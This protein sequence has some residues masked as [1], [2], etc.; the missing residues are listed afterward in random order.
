MYLGILI[1]HSW[2]RWVAIVAGIGAIW[3][4]WRISSP[5]AAARDRWALALMIALDLQLLLGLL[6]YLVSPV[7]RYA[8]HGTGALRDPTIRFFALDHPLIMCGALILVHLGRRSARKAATFQQS[9]SRRLTCY[10][11]ALIL[12]VGATPWPGLAPG[13]RPLFRI[14]GNDKD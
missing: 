11:L 10:S 5:D 8:L 1:A 9:R 13:S 7:T 6:L 3:R 2:V 12:I 14:G 4:A